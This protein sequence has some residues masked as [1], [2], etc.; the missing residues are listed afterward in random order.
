MLERVIRVGFV[1]LAFVWAEPSYFNTGIMEDGKSQP[2]KWPALVPSLRPVQEPQSSCFPPASR[3]PS[4]ADPTGQATNPPALQ[5]HSISSFHYYYFSYACLQ[6]KHFSQ[7][8]FSSVLGI[9]DEKG[10][11]PAPSS[12][13][14]SLKGLG[15]ILM[16]FNDIFQVP[17][18]RQQW[19]NSCCKS[20]C[21]F[22]LNPGRIR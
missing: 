13:V 21:W 1:S 2:T 20:N 8:L 17:G 5:D 3:L 11:V 19:Q 10:K 7:S 12:S 9:Q 4:N 18:D 15:L 16:L 14:Y 6:N 22:Y